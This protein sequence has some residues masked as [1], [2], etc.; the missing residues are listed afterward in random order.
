M[1]EKNLK[2]KELSFEV[3]SLSLE[4]LN[5]CLDLDEISL[6]GLW[7]KKQWEKELTCPQRICKGIFNFSKLI[8]FGCGWIVLDEFHLTAIAVHPSHRRL[9]LAQKLLT[10]LLR[11]AIDKGCTTSTLE[12]KNNNLAALALYKGCGFK[13]KGCRNNYYKN[14]ADALIQ[15]RS[16]SQ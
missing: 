1:N 9:G 8:A 7:S 12:V 5:V 16:L 10:N 14:G 3:I 15:W 2:S 11:E 4:N 13:T 6:Q